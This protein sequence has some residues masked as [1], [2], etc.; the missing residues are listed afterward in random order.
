MNVHEI[1]KY[2]FKPEEVGEGQERYI[3]YCLDIEHH[4]FKGLH[5]SINLKHDL[6]LVYVQ[7]LDYNSHF[8]IYE[9][10]NTEKNLIEILDFLNPPIIHE[11]K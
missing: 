6:I 7:D 10:S 11:L 1:L 4:F 9:C 5:I 3:I 2:G 8:R